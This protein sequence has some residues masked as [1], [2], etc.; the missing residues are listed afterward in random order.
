MRLVN[1]FTV[2]AYPTYLIIDGDG[3]ITNRIIGANPQ[4]SVVDQLL[5]ILKTLPQLAG[6]KAAASLR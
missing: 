2:R 3:V 5:A 6:Q 1:A 4:E